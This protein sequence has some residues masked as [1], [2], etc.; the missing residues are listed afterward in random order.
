MTYEILYIYNATDLWMIVDEDEV[1]E[2]LDDD[3]D[4]EEDEDV[5]ESID[6]K[7]N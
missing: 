6:G 3:D 4:D 5:N 1:Y 7:Y 2:V